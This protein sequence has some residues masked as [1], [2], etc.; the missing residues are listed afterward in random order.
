MKLR[1][2]YVVVSVLVA[3]ALASSVAAS[4]ISPRLSP[5]VSGRIFLIHGISLRALLSIAGIAGLIFLIRRWSGSTR[6]DGTAERGARLRGLGWILIGICL[7]AW[8]SVTFDNQQRLRRLYREEAE[9]QSMT[10]FTVDYLAFNSG[11]Q[12]GFDINPE[13]QT[14]T[15]RLLGGWSF[16]GLGW[17]LALFTGIALAATGYGLGAKRAAGFREGS[18]ILIVF[19]MIVLAWTWAPFWAQYRLSLATDAD[20]HSNF[21]GASEEYARALR[22][23]PWLKEEPSVLWAI[24]ALYGRMGRKQSPE[25]RLY[26]GNSLF[27]RG[28]WEFDRALNE[29]QMAAQ[30]DDL[31]IRRVATSQ[32]VLLLNR[33]ALAQ[34]KTGAIQSALASWGLMLEL[35]SDEIQPL[36]YMTKAAYDVALYPTAIKAGRQFLMMNRHA[37]LS[38]IV[39][40]NI[41]DCYTKLYAYDEARAHYMK[42]QDFVGNRNNRALISLVGR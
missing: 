2:H 17:Y 7:V 36:Y 3:G 13:T 37:L 18:A 41:G 30:S 26:W 16:L 39:N 32:M 38:A 4:W 5:G 29:Y 14:V 25:F 24:G 42:S 11:L 34:Y 28:R 22:I 21:S 35:S 19:A 12:L 31:A 27:S 8:L 20:A 9:F 40:S 33:K 1:W 10:T 6:R 23:D 15:G